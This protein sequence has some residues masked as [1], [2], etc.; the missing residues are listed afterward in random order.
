SCNAWQLM[1]GQIGWS[2]LQDRKSP[3]H[4]QD[5][6]NDRDRSGL[7][8]HARSCRIA[9]LVGLGVGCAALG[10]NAGLDAVTEIL[11]H[12]APVFEGTFE[13]WLADAIEQVADDVVDQT[14]ASWIVEHVSHHRAGLT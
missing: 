5:P 2:A 9:L 6:D 8:L 14:F 1:I 10:L 7:G 4:L 11:V 12:V 13:H 3:S